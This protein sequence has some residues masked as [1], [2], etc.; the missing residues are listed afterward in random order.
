MAAVWCVVWRLVYSSLFSRLEEMLY[1]G[2]LCA[3]G[4]WFLA[5]SVCNII[6][7]AKTVQHWCLVCEHYELRPQLYWILHNVL[8]CCVLMNFKLS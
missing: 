3:L 5:I 2:Y 7:D 6:D 4:L 1:H 8:G